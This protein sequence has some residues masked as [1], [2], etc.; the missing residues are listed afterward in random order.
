MEILAWLLLPSIIMGWLL[1][2]FATNNGNHRMRTRLGMLANAHFGT[3]RRFVQGGTLRADEHELFRTPV[4]AVSVLAFD[5]HTRVDAVSTCIVTDHRMMVCGAKANV[6]EIDLAAISSSH[7]YREY[8]A[9]AGYSY[10]VAI[11]RG[12]LSQHDV[13]GDIGLR[14]NTNQESQELS[15]H[16]QD[17]RHLAR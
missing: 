8:D 17:A 9:T 2:R 5:Q 6:V 10:W 3:Y 15:A 14:C 11:D 1:N 16:L 4:Q 13:H 7:V 12:P